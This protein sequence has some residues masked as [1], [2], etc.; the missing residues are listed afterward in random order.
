MKSLEKAEDFNI[1]S[2]LVAVKFTATWCGPCKKQQ[3]T[4]DKVEQEFKNVQFI[5]IDIDEVPDFNSKFNVKSIPLLILFKDGVEMKR[6]V[7]MTL[8]ESLRTAFRE[9][10]K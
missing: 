5:S 6:V 8:L 7:G 4:I 10:V 9:F 1:E 3:P 2:G